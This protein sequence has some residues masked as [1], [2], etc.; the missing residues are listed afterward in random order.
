MEKKMYIIGGVLLA[1]VFIVAVVMMYNPDSVPSEVQLTDVDNGNE[2][3][4]RKGQSLVITLEANPTTG[5]TW[6]VVESPDEHVLQQVEE[7]EFKQDSELI[8]AGG[9]QTIRFDVVGTGRTALKMVY[10]RP[11]ETDVAPEGIFYIHVVA[12]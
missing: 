5:Y 1:I 7:I 4:L 2:I 12:H 3:E 9:V 11:W 6:D 10:H 8:G